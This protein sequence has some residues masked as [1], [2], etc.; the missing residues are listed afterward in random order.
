MGR[1]SRRVD[2]YRYIHTLKA[3]ASEAGRTDILDQL[4]QLLEE[5]PWSVRSFSAEE[6]E[7]VRMRIVD[8]L[9]ELGR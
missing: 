2:D 6:A 4:R 1:Y 3:L 7:E 8:W 5:V 9:L